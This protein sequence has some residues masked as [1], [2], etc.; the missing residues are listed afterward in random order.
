MTLNSLL[1]D[2]IPLE[3]SSPTFQ[4]EPEALKRLLETHNSGHDRSKIK[5]V[6][7]VTPNNPTGSIYKK[8]LIWQFAQLCAEW[9]I[10]LILDET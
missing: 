7:L 2:V 5:A 8:E 3:T 1:I 6:V 4:P 9:K 10:A